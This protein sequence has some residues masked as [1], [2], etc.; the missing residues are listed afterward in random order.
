[1]M[2]VHAFK[3]RHTKILV[4]NSF[5]LHKRPSKYF[6]NENVEGGSHHHKTPPISVQSRKDRMIQNIKIIHFMKKYFIPF[7]NPTST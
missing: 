2:Q 3:F 4:F 6:S 7:G 1:M 5:T